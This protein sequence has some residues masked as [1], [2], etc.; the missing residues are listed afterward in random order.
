VDLQRCRALITGGSRGIG[1]AIALALAR[2]EGRVGI[3]YYRHQEAAEETAEAVRELGGEAV[4]LRGDVSERKEAKRM[5]QGFLA[6]FGGI[7]ILVNNAGMNVPGTITG[8]TDEAWQRALG[9]HLSGAFYC[10]RAAVPSMIEQGRGKI[11]IMSSVSGLRGGTNYLAYGT[12]KAGLLGFTRCLARDL[13]DDGI[14]VNAI[15]PGITETDFHADMSP[16]ARER[17]KQQRVPLHR[18]ARPEEVADVALFLLRN[19]YITG[20]TVV[21]D[22]GLTMRIA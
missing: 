2:E 13:A 12:V 20:E 19:D 21:L 1:R 18:F 8:L 10:T 14:L 6:V 11:L 3:N 9:V 7:D 15:C 16:E 5:I 22:G 4:V 17:N